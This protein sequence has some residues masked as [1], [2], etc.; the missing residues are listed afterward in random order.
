MSRSPPTE[1]RATL[2]KVLDDMQQTVDQLALA[3]DEERAAVHA[4]SSDAL[5]QAGADKQLLLQRLEQLDIER[6]QLT[7]ELPATAGT[8]PDAWPRIVQSLHR[9]RQLNQRNGS[10][11]NQRLAQV[12]EALSIL[13]GHAGEGG[14][15]DRAGGLRA[16]LRSQVLAEV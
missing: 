15:Y 6:Q 12:R 16:S 2:Q 11:V 14:L 7:R 5:N 4:R 8:G 9:C 13:T 3:L 1:M 10:A